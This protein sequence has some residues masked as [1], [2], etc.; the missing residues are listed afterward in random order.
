MVPSWFSPVPPLSDGPVLG[1]L[2]RGQRPD[3][4]GLRPR[5]FWRSITILPNVTMHN[6]ASLRNTHFPDVMSL[7]NTNLL[8]DKLGIIVTSYVTVVELNVSAL[9]PSQV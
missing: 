6:N 9:C 3:R 1:P 8:V 7:C 2:Q 5:Y 4:T